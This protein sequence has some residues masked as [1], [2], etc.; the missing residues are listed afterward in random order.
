MIG[1][2]DIYPVKI[3]LVLH[4]DTENSKFKPIRFASALQSSPVLAPQFWA[5]QSP[6]ETWYPSGTFPDMMFGNEI[7]KVSTE[8]N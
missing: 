1:S 6:N 8:I 2:N 4:S 7:L 5:K 3:T